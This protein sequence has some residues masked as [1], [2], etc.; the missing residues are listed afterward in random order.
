MV[1]LVRAEQTAIIEQAE[2]VE[3]KAPQG[4]RYL[5]T[6]GFLT[7]KQGRLEWFIKKLVLFAFSSLVGQ[8]I[9]ESNMPE[10]GK[11]NAVIV[12]TAGITAVEFWNNVTR[13][14][15]IGLP[16]SLPKRIKL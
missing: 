12:L 13:C 8:L 15:D 1:G 5:K 3:V 9:V 11:I 14:N 10:S 2:N 6:F 7:A 16:I 4:H